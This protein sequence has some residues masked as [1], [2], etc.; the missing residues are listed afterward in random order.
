MY[1]RAISK[2]VGRAEM[3]PGAKWTHGAVYR[4]ERYHR[5]GEGREPL[6]A[7]QAWR[8]YREKTNP[9]NIWL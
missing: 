3:W 4:K 2:G 6:Q 9:H 8:A 5:Y 7:S 1:R